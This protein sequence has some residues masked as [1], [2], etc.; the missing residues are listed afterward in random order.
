M[1]IFMDYSGLKIRFR[2]PGVFEQPG[3][4]MA[5]FNGSLW[6]INLELKM[7]GLLFILTLAGIF[8]KGDYY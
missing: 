3:F 4:A 5:G 8:K 1:E 6:S 2:L 7:Y